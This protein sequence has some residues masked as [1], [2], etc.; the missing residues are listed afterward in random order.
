MLPDEN[1]HLS[2]DQKQ[3]LKEQHEAVTEEVQ[4]RYQKKV[5]HREGGWTLKQMPQAVVAALSLP[6]KHLD[7][8]LRHTI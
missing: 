7:N 4:V 2:G 5:L 8:T 1:G 6:K 3:N